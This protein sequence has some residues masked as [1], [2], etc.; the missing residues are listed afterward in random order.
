MDRLGLSAASLDELKR[1]RDEIRQSGSLSDLRSSFERV[2]ELRRI[3]SDNF[4]L[5][6]IATETQDEIIARAR[7]LRGGSNA[8]PAR[9]SSNNIPAA[10]G[11]EPISEETG[12]VEDPLAAEEVPVGHRGWRRATYVALV[13]IAAIGGVFI[14]L[15]QTARRIN[16]TPT[17]VQTA[18]S[19][20]N[21]PLTPVADAEP[22]A[23]P[24]VR[25]YTDLIPG[26]VSV[27]DGDPQD[28]KDGEL[29]L[30]QLEPGR[31][32][33]KL[34]GRSGSAEFSFEVPEHGA[35]HIVPPIVANN[36]LAVAVSAEDGKGQLL[37]SAPQ[38]GVD[39]DGKPDGQAGADGLALDG[40]G[41]T[42]HEVQVSQGNDKQRFVLT[43]TKAPAL[44]VFVKSDL[45]AG[46]VTIKTGQD[47]ATVF[48]DDKPYRRK[49]DHGLIR[50]PLRVGTHS[51]RV[52]KD[53]FID[54]PPQSVD[55]EKGQDAELSFALTPAQS[56]ASLS[57][58]G[59]VP[60]TAI[61]VDNAPAGVVG[62]QGTASVKDVKPGM[63]LVELKLEG[64]TPKKLE[65]NFEAGGTVNLTA[66]DSFLER[67]AADKKAEEPPAAVAA[68]QPTPSAAPNT[69]ATP[70]DIPGEQVRR[71]GGFVHYNT[72][73]RTGNY[74][75][76][77]HSKIGGFLRHDKLQWYAGYQNSE[78]YVM[79]SVDGKH[80]TVREMRDG[81][82]AEVH[83]IPF[84]ANSDQWVQ[85]DM[86]V[87]PSSISARIKTPNGEWNDLGTVSSDGRDF[88]QD[89]VGF[90]V[91]GN[92]EVAVAHFHFAGTP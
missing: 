15:V 75:F 52:H 61:L 31:H 85:V 34:S 74:S 83:R 90:Y 59:A 19:A 88:T 10:A 91:P 29:V 81:K 9:N 23:K 16:L 82:A 44:T 37:S 78:N 41:S 68:S 38:L 35:P 62:A 27:D 6:L 45:N 3:Y 65:R 67:V 32:S 21:A 46:F 42:D 60:G 43:Y 5:Q 25:L 54:P 1:I 70:V 20:A 79:F 63:H 7:E 48:I 24:S 76:E 26:T 87:K 2:G 36:A 71:G 40:L 86:S 56:L 53:G 84:D 55:M 39:L 33:V 80:A 4:D 11:L 14:Y 73:K 89:K 12:E 22:P 92:D 30:D 66:S 64:A 72:P 50:L 58:Q 8:F 28:L 51:I 18:P 49:T 47:D 13:F 77:A 17:T 57:V 69:P